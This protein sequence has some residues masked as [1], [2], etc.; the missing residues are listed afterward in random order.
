M[1]DIFLQPPLDFPLFTYV[2][3]GPGQEK[4]RKAYKSSRFEAYYY[5]QRLVAQNGVCT[6]ML[7][8]VYL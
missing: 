3:D 1:H 5:Y 7:I 2:I 8:F 4:L 6:G